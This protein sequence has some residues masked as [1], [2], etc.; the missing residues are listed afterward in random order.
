MSAL[1]SALPASSRAVAF[2]Q[3]VRLP[4]VFSAW[5]D[6]CLGALAIAALPDQGIRFLLLLLASTCL[7]WAGMIW[8][9]FFDLEQDRRERSFRPLPFER[10]SVRL[11]AVLGV[12]FLAAGVACAGLAD[13]DAGELRW[14][15]LVPAILLAANILLYDA[16]LK[17]TWAGPIAMGSCRF[18][19]VLLG[20][21]VA[22]WPGAVG[23]LLG[24]VVGTYITGVTWFARTEARTSTPNA[25]RGAAIV[26]LAALVLALAVPVVAEDSGLSAQTSPLFPYLLM[27]LGFFLATPVLRAIDNPSPARV[28]AAVKRCL[29]GL[30]LVDAV[31][32]TALAGSMGMAL[33]LLLVP[34]LYLGRWLYA[35]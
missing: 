28:Q 13:V 5:A 29:V 22:A 12:G 7:Y 11:A 2:A 20:L 3:L 33:A 19:N 16:W 32:A 17:R 14:R 35:T 9:D 26:M 31:L 6:I 1:H 21:S 8:N 30:I 18:L 4:N 23:V 25:L 24:L 27:A 34:A 10:I 15:S